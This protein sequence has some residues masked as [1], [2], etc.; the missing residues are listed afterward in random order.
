VIVGAPCPDAWALFEAGDVPGYLDAVAAHV[1]AVVR[2]GTV[3]VVVLA[4]ASMAAVADRF[5]GGAVPVLAGPAAA[6]SA[7]AA[8]LARAGTATDN[9]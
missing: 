9:P 5:T 7:A 8:L 4:Q 2:S 3:D 1:D 6:V